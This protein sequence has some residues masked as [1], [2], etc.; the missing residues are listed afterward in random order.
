MNSLLFISLFSGFL[1]VFFVIQP[2]FENFSPFYLL[3]L[4]GSCLITF[5][6]FIV[7]K[8]NNVTSPIGYFVWSGIVIY[9]L[10]IVL[11]ILDPV[12][13]D[14]ITLILIVISSILINI[15]LLCMT[16]AFQRSQKFYASIFCLVYIQILWSVL[17]GF[18]IF[19]EYLN[20]F[21]V[22]GAF[23]IILSGLFSIPA[24]YKQI[25]E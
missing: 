20:L 24:Q 5:T 21:A 23:F 16:F 1:G 3:V 6:T 2:G 17:I 19:N 14:F 18:F 9:P 4:L 12:L 7:N 10:S 15:A 22:I 13:V 25:N 11:F 8:Y